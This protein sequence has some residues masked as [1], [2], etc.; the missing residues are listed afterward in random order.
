MTTRRDRNRK[1]GTTITAKERRLNLE[2]A[3]SNGL[4]R[5][6]GNYD[7]LVKKKRRARAAKKEADKAKQGPNR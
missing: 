3:H 5:F 7:S 4:P 2:Q 6:G 1:L